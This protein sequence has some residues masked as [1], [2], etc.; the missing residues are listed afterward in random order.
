[1]HTSRHPHPS[2]GHQHPSHFDRSGKEH[3]TSSLI[4]DEDR[5]LLLKLLSN[6]QE[7]HE[8][9][10]MLQNSPPEIANLGYLILRVFD[11]S[12]KV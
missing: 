9:F 10:R 8:M 4:T 5:Q 1:M 6:P 7:A 2:H 12:I 11:C 3:S